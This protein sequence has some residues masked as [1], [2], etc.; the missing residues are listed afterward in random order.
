M[1][2]ERTVQVGGIADEPTGEEAERIREA[3]FQHWPD[4]RM[5]SSWASITHVRVT[6][7]WLRFS[8]WNVSPPLVAEWVREE[9]VGLKRVLSLAR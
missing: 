7:Q 5:R 1:Q 9:D 8:D 4:G 6:P 3:Y 2:D